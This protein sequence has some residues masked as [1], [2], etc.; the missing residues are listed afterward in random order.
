MPEMREVPCA[1]CGRPI[2]RKATQLKH[3]PVSYCSS[4]CMYPHSTIAFDCAQCGRHT[5]KK[6]NI[7]GRR[8][9]KHLYCSRDCHQAWIKANSPTGPSHTSWKRVT[10]QCAHC[11]KTFS[12]A[13]RS[14]KSATPC[15]SKACQYAWRSGPQS[16]LWKGGHADY[17][18]PNWKTQRRAARDRD[19]HTCQSCGITSTVHGRAMQVHHIRPFKSFGY[20]AGVNDLYLEANDLSNLISLCAPC[21]ISLE[22]GVL[23]VQPRLIY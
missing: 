2:I 4:E 18:G 9:C 21:H 15:C 5:V 22:R 13:P 16:N 20:I 23:V 17:Y 6:G 12:R 3:Y 19:G 11:D 8:L 14:V 1:T 7:T 10:L